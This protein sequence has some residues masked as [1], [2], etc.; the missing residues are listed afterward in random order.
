MSLGDVEA[1]LQGWFQALEWRS[2][3][4]N[5]ERRIERREAP[6]DCSQNGSGIS[7]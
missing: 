6:C 2:C 7:T 5:I 1:F 3:T 4:A